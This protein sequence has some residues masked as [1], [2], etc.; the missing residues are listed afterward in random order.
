MT[1]Q[2]EALQLA[3]DRP[4]S[5]GDDLYQWAIDAEGELRRLH[6]S[7]TKLLGALKEIAYRLEG[8][9]IWGGRDW[10][11]NPIHPVWYL[12]LRDKARAAIAK[13]EGEAK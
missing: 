13:A 12:P 7:N 3:D 6:E 4:T 11:Y 9:R 2:P 1:T 8:S 5:L 10:H